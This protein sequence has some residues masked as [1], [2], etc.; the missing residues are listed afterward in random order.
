MHASVCDTAD[1]TDAW[2]RQ[3]RLEDRNPVGDEVLASRTG[4]TV[5]I[6]LTNRLHG[7][8]LIPWSP[9]HLAT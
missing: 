7:I 5:I 3:I 9:Y 1:P 2:K 6:Y 4:A 8:I